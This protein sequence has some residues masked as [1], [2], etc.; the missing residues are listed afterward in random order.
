MFSAAIATR[1][2][3]T[4]PNRA[5]CGGSVENALL[6]QAVLVWAQTL[7]RRLSQRHLAFGLKRLRSF[8]S[9]IEVHAGPSAHGAFGSYET[10]SERALKTM[11]NFIKI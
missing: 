10:Y 2:Q 1:F 4:L 6:L 3:L 11:I 5:A 8:G 9:L 7:W